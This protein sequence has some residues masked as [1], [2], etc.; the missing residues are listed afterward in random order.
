[1]TRKNIKTVLGITA[2]ISVGIVVGNV[3]KATIPI[4]ANVV[5]RIGC[6]LGGFFIGTVVAQPLKKSTDEL[7]DAMADAFEK[8]KE[9]NLHVVV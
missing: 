2:Q 3:I 5:N 7:V 1:M 4:N 6:A 9:V 8:E